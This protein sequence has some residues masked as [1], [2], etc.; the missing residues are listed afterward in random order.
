MQSLQHLL[1]HQKRFVRDAAHQLRTPLATLKVELAHAERETD[2]VR[3][4]AALQDL[5]HAIDRLARLVHQL[6][7]LARAEPGALTHNAFQPVP[8]APL[9]REGVAIGAINLR[10]Q[11]PGPFTKEQIELLETFA[12]QAVIA[13]ENVRLFNDLRNALDQQTATSDILK[14]IASSPTAVSN[15]VPR[16]PMVADGV[17]TVLVDFDDP[18]MKRN[19][20]L[21]AVSDTEPPLGS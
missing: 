16:T 6:L 9:L 1:D 11:V 8:L 20:P 12:A 17:L 3:R 2:P 18:D 10:R 19:A 5:G 21:V 13:I 4:Q 7:G 14:V 15:T